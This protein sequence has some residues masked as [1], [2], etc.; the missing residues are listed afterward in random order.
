[1]NRNVRIGCLLFGIVVWFVSESLFAAP[2]WEAQVV[3]AVEGMA[4]NYFK[5]TLTTAFGTFTYEYT[6]LGSAFS[7]YLE[8]KLATSLQG[9][10]RIKLFARH[11]VENMDPE[12]RN[13]YRDFFKATDVDAVLYGK[14][15][16]EPN[17]KV[18][19]HLELASLTTGEL[20]G[21]TDVYVPSEDLPPRIDLEPPALGK[22]MNEKK[23]LENLLAASKGSLVV[24]A[25]TSRGTSAVY[26]NGEDMTIHVFVNQDAYLKVYH[27][28]V[29]GKVQLIFPNPFYKDNRVKGGTL[30]TIPDASYPFRFQMGPPYG[31]EFIKVVASTQQF[32]DMETAFSELP[33]KPKDVL[34]RGLTVLKKSDGGGASGP[35]SAGISV[36]GTETAEALV[37]YTIV[38]K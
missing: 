31:T 37:S 33:G 22:A 12:F 6:G 13:L 21:S 25:V 4:K 15:F 29:N 17:G 38:E 1:M 30:V 27:I 34:S 7:R 24:R 3:E 8:E 10:Q 36:I 5:P 11:A 32:A 20:L 26:K 28:D 9:S 18:R 23:D 2:P 19:L 14:Y 35:A 16:K